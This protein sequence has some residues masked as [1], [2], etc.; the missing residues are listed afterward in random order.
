M[1]S[2]TTS[3]PNQPSPQLLLTTPV[4]FREPHSFRPHDFLQLPQV[5]QNGPRNSNHNKRLGASRCLTSSLEIKQIREEYGEKE[6]KLKAAENQKVAK[7]TTA[8]AV[9]GKRKSKQVYN[10]KEVSKTFICYIF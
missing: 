1:A 3:L 7:A 10:V 6:R 2:P 9:G 5:A 4:S 8:K